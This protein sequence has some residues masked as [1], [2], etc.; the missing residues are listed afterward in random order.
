MNYFKIN[1]NYNFIVTKLISL[2]NN[3]NMAI[4]AFSITL[5]FMI[6]IGI[7]YY[8]LMRYLNIYLYSIFKIRN[9]KPIKLNLLNWKNCL[10]LRNDWYLIYFFFEL[11]LD[12]LVVFKY[13]LVFFSNIILNLWGWSLVLCL[14]RSET[15]NF[16]G[17]QSV[18]T[19]V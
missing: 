6:N 12:L 9:I 14:F 8:S 11:V 7:F 17:S 10:I 15:I 4:L 18:I 16:Y 5:H 3:N 2:I 19:G 13:T 1:L